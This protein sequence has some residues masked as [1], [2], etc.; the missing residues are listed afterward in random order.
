[1]SR[2]LH[3]RHQADLKGFMVTEFLSK[4]TNSNNFPPLFPD[5]NTPFI[6]NQEKNAKLL[7]AVLRNPAPQDWSYKVSLF[8]RSGAT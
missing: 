7:T 1:M 6:H 8:A 4:L 2:S 5:T 3:A